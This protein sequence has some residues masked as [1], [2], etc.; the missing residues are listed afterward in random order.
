[1]TSSVEQHVSQ[2]YKY[3]WTTEVESNRVPAG[4]NE[5]VI[6]LISEKK[7]EPDFGFRPPAL[8][9]LHPGAI[10]NLLSGIPSHY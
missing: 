4:L 1:M 2:P 10:A 9:S 8:R 3:G 7:E 5:D 6:R